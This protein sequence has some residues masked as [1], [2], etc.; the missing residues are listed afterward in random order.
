MTGVGSVAERGGW[1]VGG[2]PARVAH[3]CR[4][5][6]LSGRLRAGSRGVDRA[7]GMIVARAALVPAHQGT[8]RSRE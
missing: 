7:G 4:G 2:T 6:R 1:G 5:R 8:H 3:S